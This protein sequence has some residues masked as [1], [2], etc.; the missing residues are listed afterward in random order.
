[1][2][3]SACDRCS[4]PTLGYSTFP[5]GSLSRLSG[6]GLPPA[7]K[8]C[9][10]P[11]GW[12]PQGKPVCPF[13]RPKGRGSTTAGTGPPPQLP[14]SYSG[15]LP[16][17]R[18]GFS[19]PPQGVQAPLRQRVL[20]TAHP[21]PFVPAATG[22]GSRP[23]GS[24][25]RPRYLPPSRLRYALAACMALSPYEVPELGVLQARPGVHGPQAGGSEQGGGRTL[26][27][28]GLAVVRPRLAF[29][30]QRGLQSPSAPWC[31]TAP[32]APACSAH[33]MGLWV[34][35]IPWV[36][37]APTFPR[38]ALGVRPQDPFRVAQSRPR[39]LGVCGLRSS[40]RL[41][42]RRAAFGAAP[43][44]TSPGTRLTRRSPSEWQLLGYLSGPGTTRVRVHP[45]SRA[46]PRPR[47]SGSPK[48][49]LT[50]S[51]RTPGNA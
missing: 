36:G 22:P 19:P 48:G 28:T 11:L 44:R 4:F 29:P 27:V 2:G 32:S 50:K 46:T 14:P 43:A 13:L 10:G 42:L 45:H 37:L 3:V 35:P 47:S 49:N 15:S 34:H 26:P 39:S 40:Q 25:V 16:L 23:R 21:S 24:P 38:S 41:C 9:R 5:S 7:P 8:W 6:Q 51:L 12:T 31:L 1:M 33:V 20:P 18:A 30:G 17:S